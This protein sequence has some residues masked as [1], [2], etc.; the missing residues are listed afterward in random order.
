MRAMNPGEGAENMSPFSG[1]STFSG[2]STGTPRLQTPRRSLTN[3]SSRMAAKSFLRDSPIIHP[4]PSSTPKFRNGSPSVFARKTLPKE[5]D[6]LKTIV[7]ESTTYGDQLP[8]SS[9][10]S[11]LEFFIVCRFE[12]LSSEDQNVLRHASIIGPEFSRDVIYG[13]LS[14]RLRTEMFSSLISLVKN[15]WVTDVNI[16]SLSEYSFVHPLLYQTLYDL[17]P[18][19]DKARLH[20]AVATFLEDSYEGNATYFKQLGYHYGLSATDCSS[21]ALEY[22]VRAAVYSM[23]N[24]PLYY[25]ESLYLLTKALEFTESAMDY[26]AILGIVMDRKAKLSNKKKELIEEEKRALLPQ[27]IRTPTRRYF[28]NFSNAIVP[29][30]TSHETEVEDDSSFKNCNLTIKG[31]DTFL[32]LFEKMEDELENHYKRVVLENK[33]GTTQVWQIPHLIRRK[34][35]QSKMFMKNEIRKGVEV[36]FNKNNIHSSRM[37]LLF[38]ETSCK[39]INDSRRPL[40]QNSPN[41]V[42]VSSK[43]NRNI[44]EIS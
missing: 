22:Y 42:F 23:S 1:S 3:K 30:Q 25:D 33:V 40:D 27:V 10:T 13:I 36:T 6:E 9:T 44:C 28:I 17:T 35:I 32:D 31:T 38:G 39:D 5:K 11:R 43:M 14:P 8:S 20:Y 26:G 24:G 29:L 34:Q 15:Q 12:K 19:S 37:S 16:D 2:T 21:K 4:H 18:A 41:V 7:Y